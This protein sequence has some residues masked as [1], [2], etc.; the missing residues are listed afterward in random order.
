M[1]ALTSP[2]IESELSYAYLHAVASNAGMSCQAGNRHQDNAGIDARITAWGPFPKGGSRIEVDLN[3]QLKATCK[4]VP[5][6]ENGFS[7]FLAGVERY[8][9]LRAETVATPRILVV[10]LLPSDHHEWLSLSD[11]QLVLK[12]C[13]YWRSL[14]GAPSTANTSGETIRIPWGNRFSP[15]ALSNVIAAISRHDIPKFGEV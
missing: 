3:V 9:D 10:L 7:Y 6:D 13:A 14:V 4:P 8:N 11:E 5:N 12:R 2:N 1:Q 15:E